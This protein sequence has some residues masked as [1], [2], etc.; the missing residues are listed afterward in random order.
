MTLGKG[1][2]TLE[3]FGQVALPPGAVRDGEVIDADVVST[4]VRQLWAQA[5]FRTKRVVV[6]VANQKVV[7]RQVDLPWLPV[8]ELRKSL[9]FSVQKLRD[10]FGH[11]ALSYGGR[12]PSHEAAEML[13][14]NYV[15][16]AIEDIFDNGL[17][18]FIQD[19]LPALALV[20]AQIEVDY[21]FYA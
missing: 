12:L 19:F 13:E 2:A 17:H 6:G 5:R 4:A 3:R 21:R 1:T 15:C 18:E 9:A 20:S 10:N 8:D 16:H 11:L 7:V 14:A